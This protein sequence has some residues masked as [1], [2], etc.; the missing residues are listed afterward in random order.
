MSSQYVLKYDNL[1]IERLNLQALSLYDTRLDPAIQTATSILDL[2]CGPGTLVERIKRI[3]PKCHYLGIDGDASAIAR[4]MSNHGSTP[5]VSFT[6]TNIS[7]EQLKNLGVKQF[8]LIICRLVLWSLPGVNED[9]VRE[10]RSLLRPLGILYAFE[11]DDKNLTF[12]PEKPALESIVG[13]WQKMVLSRGQNP[14]IGRKLYSYFVA[15][16]FADVRSF[17]MAFTASGSDASSY[18]ALMKN[19]KGIFS[20][21]TDA[22]VLTSS[23]WNE[24][25]KQ[26][27]DVQPNDFVAEHHY[28]VFGRAP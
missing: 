8:D 25:L 2:G 19:L 15:A 11:P 10:L 7:R 5:G 12:E 4:A 21:Q 18:L 28:S 9:F 1:E 17:P 27:D 22:G 13:A 23:Y 16:G 26:F 6:E 20:N 14:F 24:G 3:N